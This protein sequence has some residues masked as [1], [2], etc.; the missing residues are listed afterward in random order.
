MPDL[1]N[2]SNMES[3]SVKS[4]YGFTR[5]NRY[6]QEPDGSMWDDIWDNTNTT[7]YWGEA[8]KGNLMPE[9]RDLFLKYFQSGDKVLEAGCGA[10]QVVI[11]MR[12]QGFDCHGLD[13]AKKIIQN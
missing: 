12:E 6:W 11:A 7:E 4:E 3:V 8:L 13:F 2:L 9:Y 10:G 5:L 1:I